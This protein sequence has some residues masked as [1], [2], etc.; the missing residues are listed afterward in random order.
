LPA[1]DVAERGVD[2][3]GG[4]CDER[5]DD[6]VLGHS[7]PGGFAPECLVLPHDEI[8]EGITDG[9]SASA[10]RTRSPCSRPLVKSASA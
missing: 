6:D 1:N 3:D 4:D 5:D 7:L 8:S 2:A 9:L 10:I